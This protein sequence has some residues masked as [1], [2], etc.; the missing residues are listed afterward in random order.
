MV[1]LLFG[2]FIKH[3]KMKNRIKCPDMQKPRN[4]ATKTKQNYYFDRQKIFIFTEP[5][6]GNLL[7]NLE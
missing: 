2:Q 3:N 5:G 4:R 6:V 7:D 1:T